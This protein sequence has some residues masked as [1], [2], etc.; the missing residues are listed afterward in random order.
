[1]QCN[2]SLATSD[3]SI[4]FPTY[5]VPTTDVG[6]S[7]VGYLFI[8]L[9]IYFNKNTRGLTISNFKFSRISTLEK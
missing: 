9:S 2:A 5:I 6:T 4:G 1:L 7:F 8:Y 3:N